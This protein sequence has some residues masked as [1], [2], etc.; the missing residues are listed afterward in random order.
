MGSTQSFCYQ[1]DIPLG[2]EYQTIYDRYYDEKI[3]PESDQFEDRRN[4]VLQQNGYRS[5]V[6]VKTEKLYGVDWESNF[7]FDENGLLYVGIYN[8]SMDWESFENWIPKVVT[9]C[10]TSFGES[11]LPQDE[12]LSLLLDQE[13]DQVSNYWLAEDET[14]LQLI[15][16]SARKGAAFSICIGKS[17]MVDL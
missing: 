4:T 15:R 14:F 9:D 3:D 5:V 1:T 16:L 13:N 8:T 17:D 10:Y 2:T 12:L 11:N 7:N 6:P